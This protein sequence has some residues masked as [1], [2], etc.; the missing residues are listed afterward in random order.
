VAERSP[1]IGTGDKARIT[2]RDLL[3]MSSGLDFQES[4]E[5]APLRSSVV[6][7]LYTRGLNDMAGFAAQHPVAHAP[8]SVWSYASGDSL[9]LMAAL[10][11]VVGPERY[12]DWPWTALFEV[13]GMDSATF[14][15]DGAGTFVGSSYLYATPRDLAKYGFLFLQD[16]RWQDR[17]LLPEGWTAQ[18]GIGL[19]PFYG[20]HWWTN[21]A[22]ADGARAWPEAPEDTIAGMGHWGQKLFVMPSRDLVIVRTGD[23]RDRSFDN[24]RFLRLVLE[25]FAQ[26]AP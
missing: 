6:A 10:R 12:G 20:L 11:D 16:G 14:E 23:D 24:D 25:T 17:Q 13:I 26:E 22:D 2:Y 4:Y 8:G 21:R 3:A 15:R 18:A 7:M 1:W 5:Y 9:I 19:R